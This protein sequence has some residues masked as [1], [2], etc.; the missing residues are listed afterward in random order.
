MNHLEQGSPST[1]HGGFQAFPDGFHEWAGFTVH[2]DFENDISQL[3]SRTCRQSSQSEAFRHTVFSN[4][5]RS[6]IKLL[7]GFLFDEKDLPPIP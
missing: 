1:I 7:E 2:G 6:Q 3:Y 5:S 4:N